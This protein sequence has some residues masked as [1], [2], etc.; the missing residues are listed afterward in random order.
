VLLVGKDLNDCGGCCVAAGP[1][2]GFATPQDFAT[3][4]TGFATPQT[5]FD[6]PPAAAATQ[7][8]ARPAAERL[9]FDHPILHLN[10]RFVYGLDH[11]IATIFHFS[12]ALFDRDSILC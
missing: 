11:K 1:N 10:R 4:Q 9:R 3:A 5:G 8:T 7:P 2:A 6:T 12:T